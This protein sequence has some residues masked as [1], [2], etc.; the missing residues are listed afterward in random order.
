MTVRRRGTPVRR[1]AP[2]DLYVNLEIRVMYVT[3][4]TEVEEVTGLLRSIESE[5]VN[6]GASNSTWRP[7]VLYVQET[8]GRTSVVPVQ[9]IVTV[10]VPTYTP[11]VTRP[12]TG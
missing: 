10:Y 7:K 4:G 8:S 11:I 3:E 12:S 9:D 6:K 1:L 5:Q 2:E